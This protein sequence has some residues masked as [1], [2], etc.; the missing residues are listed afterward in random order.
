MARHA[1]GSLAVSMLL[2]QAIEQAKKAGIEDMEISWM[3][4]TNH[5]IL[6]GGEPAGEGDAEISGIREGLVSAGPIDSSRSMSTLWRNS[7]TF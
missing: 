3:L 5:A 1:L 4:E 2:A 7:A 6:N